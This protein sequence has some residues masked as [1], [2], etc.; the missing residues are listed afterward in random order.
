VRGGAMK[1]YLN[2]RGKRILSALD[3]F[4]RE[5]GVSQTAVSLAWLIQNP[6]VSAPIASATSRL[7]LNAFAEAMKIELT[8]DE[9]HLLNQA[10]D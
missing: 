4:A 2:G 8:S 9:I 7:Q 10:S 1:K 6:L 3:K 5:R